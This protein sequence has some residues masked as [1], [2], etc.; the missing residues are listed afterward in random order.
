[1]KGGQR[2]L[3][4]HGLLVVSTRTAYA[5]LLNRP[6]SALAGPGWCI[7]RSRLVHW[8]VQVGALVGWGAARAA[9]RNHQC[10]YTD[11]LR[12]PAQPTRECIGRSRLV[13][14]SV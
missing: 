7:G 1:V 11:G 14:W 9:S 6:G 4:S 12:R 3:P 10:N 2:V 8:S 13:H 5:V